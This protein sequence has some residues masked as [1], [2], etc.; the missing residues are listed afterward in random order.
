MQISSAVGKIRTTAVTN[1]SLSSS[2]DL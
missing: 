1:V 2:K